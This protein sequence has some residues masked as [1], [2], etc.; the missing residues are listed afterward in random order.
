MTRLE[1]PRGSELYGELTDWLHP[2]VLPEGIFEGDLPAGIY[3]YKARLDGS[4]IEPSGRTRSVGGVRNAVLSVGGLP[5]PLLFAPAAP[6]VQ[7]LIDGTL[8]VFVA[9]RRGQ[10]H[11]VR[12]RH[13]EDPGDPFV[14]A[15]CTPHVEEDEHVVLTAVLPVSSD[16]VELAFEVDGVRVGEVLRWLRPKRARSEIANVYTIFVDRFRRVPEGAWDDPRRDA[17][18]GGNLDGITASLDELRSLGVD[19]LYLT[20][21]QMAASCHRYDL[22]DPLRVD[23]ALGGEAAF[24]RLIE[25]VRARGMKLLLDFS[26]VHVGRG[27]PAFQDV[28]ARGRASAFAAW[29]R[30]DGDRLRHYGHRDDA[31]LLDLTHPEVRALSMRTV[32][33][34]ASLGVDG[35]R[36]D[37]IADVPLDFA[38]AVRTRL[39][40]LRPEAIVLGEVVPPHAWRFSGAVDL[41]TDFAFHALATDFVAKR[42]IDAAAFAEGLR[43]SEIVRGTAEDRTVRFLSTH[44]HPRFASIARLHGDASRTALGLLLLLASPGIPALLYGE[45]LGLSSADVAMEVEGAWADRMP[46]PW[47][48]RPEAL[49]PFV[50]RLLQL[51]RAEPALG[52]GRSEIL[53]AE[54]PLLVFRR[55]GVVDIAINASDEPLEIDLEDDELAS[56]ELLASTGEARVEGHTFHLGPNAGVIVKRTRSVEQRAR[57]AAFVH[58]LPVLRDRDFAAGNLAVSGRPLRLDLSLT[59]RCNLRCAHCLTLAPQ[60]T[61]AGTARTMSHAVLDRLRD[62]FAHAAWFGFVHGGESL[63]SPMLFPVLEA[64]RAERPDAMVHLLTNG[65]LLRRATTERLYAHGVRSLFVSLDGATAATNDRIRVG[66][67]FHSVCANVR[68]AV[69][70]RNEQTLDLRIGLSYVVM[71]SNLAELGAFVDLAARLGVDWIKLEEPVAATS[72]AREE[73]IDTGDER[74]ARAVDRARGLGLVAVDHVAPPPVWRCRLDERSRSFVESDE[75]A[76]RTTIHPCRAAWERACVFPNGDVAIDDFL[77]PIVG[78]VLA[79]PLAILWNG[80]EATAHRERARRLWICDGTPTCA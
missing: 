12:V 17:P 23:P 63:V 4:W 67:D 27:F 65:K 62:D 37:A 10:G 47:R 60:K 55:G 45:E 46:M 30:W 31:P 33:H 22:V 50:A 66:G 80:R 2:R 39:L 79:T 24:T 41:A 68:D 70:L 43:R 13:R 78:N 8:R 6:C 73:L 3:S 29:F 1:L 59:E 36:F 11:A 35:F 53:Y 21:V 72:F 75:F 25:G 69:T 26:F 51:R 5:E 16:A 71:K 42:A 38:R 77:H 15:E 54:G 74:I 48:G 32:E 64:I 58:A 49:R 61:A 52:R 20:P 40:Q 56:I 19:T 57:R 9:L 34:L 7:E 76:N 14:A 28:R 44:D 18:A